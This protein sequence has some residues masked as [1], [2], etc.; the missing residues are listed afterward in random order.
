MRA[1]RSRPVQQRRWG[2][3][4]Q[5]EPAMGRI[6][7][8]VVS[9]PCHTVATPPLLSYLISTM[10]A[11]PPCPQTCPAGTYSSG[12]ATTCKQCNPGFYS[13]AGSGVCSPW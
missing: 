8:R 11:A 6:S 12:G 9:L 2:P 4:L 5:G 10:L 13:I 7:Y 3:D 1:V